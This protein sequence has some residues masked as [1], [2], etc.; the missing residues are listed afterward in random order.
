MLTT[1]PLFI[2]EERWRE[3]R[4]AMPSV[5]RTEKGKDEDMDG[6]GWD[7]REEGKERGSRERGGAE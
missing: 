1:T 7:G 6:E 4:K 3:N 5:H 2:F